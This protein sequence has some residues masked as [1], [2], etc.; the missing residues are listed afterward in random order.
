MRVRPK[1]IFFRFFL[2]YLSIGQMI[3]QNGLVWEKKVFLPPSH[4]NKKSTLRWEGGKKSSNFR[5]FKTHLFSCEIYLRFRKST[6]CNMKSNRLTTDLAYSDT[7]IIDKL[8]CIFFVVDNC[9]ETTTTSDVKP[10]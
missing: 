4:L 10:M 8:L 2:S 1:K 9:F 7:T 3:T 5:I 6:F